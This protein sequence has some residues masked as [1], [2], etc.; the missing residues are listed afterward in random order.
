MLVYS[1]I[2]SL[3]GV[4]RLSALIEIVTECIGSCHMNVFICNNRAEMNN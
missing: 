4:G 2:L 1:Y 3:A